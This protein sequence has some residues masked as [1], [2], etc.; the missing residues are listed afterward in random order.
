MRFEF[1]YDACISHHPK[2]KQVAEQIAQ[3]LKADSVNVWL[4]EWTT[5][6]KTE[7]TTQLNDTR[8][9]VLC[10]SA[11]FTNADW[12]KIEHDTL[13]FRDVMEQKRRF[14]LIK[15]DDTSKN[16]L[17]QFVSFTWNPN[18][19]TELLKT[20]KPEFSTRSNINIYA[21]KP[22][23]NNLVPVYNDIG[24]YYFNPNG[25]HVFIGMGDKMQIRELG[26]GALLREFTSNKS[27]L[28]CIT[29]NMDQKY[30]V[31]C[32]SIYYGGLTSVIS[33]WD[34]KTKKIAA[35]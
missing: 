29:G 30:A 5:T 14:V 28:G 3:K 35:L 18:D 26:T 31:S 25:N 21:A 20:C 9:F 8:T 32:S 7:R 33:L 24:T 17:Q 11:N 19:N 23:I 6:K 10:I 27:E 1:V 2:D 15:I 12:K 16:A 34:L 13:S 4:D 22:L